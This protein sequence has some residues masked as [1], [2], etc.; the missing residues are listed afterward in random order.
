MSSFAN[1]FL[2]FSA[3]TP[4]EQFDE[5][6]WLSN[7]IFEILE[8]SILSISDR[9]FFAE[10]LYSNAYTGVNSLLSLDSGSGFILIIFVI[11]FFWHFFSAQLSLVSTA[12]SDF[13]SISLLTVIHL[14]TGTLFSFWFADFFFSREYVN[15]LGEILSTDHIFLPQIDL[16]FAVDE[17]RITFFLAFFLLGG[18]ESEDEEDFFLSEETDLAFIEE[19]VAPLFVVNL[20]KD[21]QENGALYLKVCSVFSFVLISNLR[22]RIPYGDTTTSSLIL[23]FWVSFTVFGSLLTL[24]IRKHGINYFFSL[25][26]PSGCPFPLLFLLIPIEFLSYCFRVISLCVRL[27]ANRR[28]GHTLRKVIMGFS[29]IR[30]TLGEGYA[31]AGFLPAIVIFILVFLERAVAAI[32]AY[33]FT[34]L[35]CIYLKDLYVAH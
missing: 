15:N 6:I 19:I 33:I 28:A 13:S 30:F 3:Y 7:Q 27:F 22:G 1:S 32:Q 12:V 20:G 21:I 29:Y 25:F 10:D 11:A 2:I 8:G 16:S 34:I 5:V 18:G 9:E 23:T 35:I 26:R 24:R 31:L 14:F 4:L 17:R